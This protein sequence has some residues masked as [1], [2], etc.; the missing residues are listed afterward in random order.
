M[1]SGSVAEKKGDNM[2]LDVGDKMFKDFFYDEVK[3]VVCD[4]ISRII[5][6]VLTD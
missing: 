5:L 6:K 4:E 2:L 1:F 3:V